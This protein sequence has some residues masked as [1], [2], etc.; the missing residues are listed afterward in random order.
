MFT[1][2]RDS[3][4]TS[5]GRSRARRGTRTRSRTEVG[6]RDPCIH[7]RT[8]PL[9]GVSTTPCS[10]SISPPDA[11]A[12]YCSKPATHVWP[13]SSCSHEEPDGY[14]C[15]CVFSSAS[16]RPRCPTARAGC[17]AV[18]AACA[19]TRWRTYKFGAGAAALGRSGVERRRHRAR[20]DAAELNSS[21]RCARPMG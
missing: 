10:S 4:R 5:P 14:V 12:M 8:L 17:R 19:A 7:R 11:I 20:S 18:W 6:P 16:P 13:S 3:S 15:A 1:Y 2:R 9:C 21:A